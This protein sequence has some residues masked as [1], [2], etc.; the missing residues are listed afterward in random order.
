[1]FTRNHFV[2][3]LA[4]AATVASATGFAQP[5]PIAGKDFEQLQQLIKPGAD[6]SRWL[7]MDW[8]TSVWEARQRA[9]ALGKPILLWSGGGAPP[10]G[11]C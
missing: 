4:V 7:G 8:L 5:Q 11:G 9:A 2:G 10:L 6:E 3:V 1:M